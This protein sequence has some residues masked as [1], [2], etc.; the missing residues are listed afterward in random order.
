MSDFDEVAD[1]YEQITDEAMGLPGNDHDYFERYKMRYLK[2]LFEKRKKETGRKIKLLDYGCGVGLMAETIFKTIPEV[3]IHGFDVS[4][5]S[6]A[7]VKPWLKSGGNRFT[8]ELKELDYDYDF[9]LLCTVMHHVE[10]DERAQVVQ[11]IYE[12]LSPGGGLIILEMN[13]KNPLVKSFIARIPYDKDAIMLTT[14][15]AETYLKEG[16]FKNVWSKYIVFFPKQLAHLRFLDK[17]LGWVPLGAQFI[18]AGE[19]GD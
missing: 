19:K 17:Y 8:S 14:K 6:I 1:G 12:R 2:P 18:T 4:S 10:L 9:A 11:N 7:N 15:E 16:G 3:I 5:R 13:M